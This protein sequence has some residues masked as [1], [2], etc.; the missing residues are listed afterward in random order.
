MGSTR[1]WK[2]LTAA[3][4]VGAL[5]TGCGNQSPTPEPVQNRVS[6]TAFNGANACKD[7]EAYLED[8][9]VLQMKTQLEASRDE[10]P[11]WGWWGGGLFG[12]GGPEVFAGT[13]NDKAS[14]APPQ[15]APTNY[16]TTNNQVAGVDEADFVKNDGTRIFALSGQTLYASRSWPDRPRRSRHA[17]D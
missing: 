12:R 1:W 14:A 6:L 7:L 13:A 8:T 10:V 2:W 15:A 5:G 11:S 3:G 9:A 4:A 16:T 17:Q